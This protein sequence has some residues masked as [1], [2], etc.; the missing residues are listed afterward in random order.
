MEAHWEESR[1]YRHLR[2]EPVPRPLCFALGHRVHESMT[3]RIARG[4]EVTRKVHRRHLA[5]PHDQV[6]GGRRSAH[7]LRDRAGCLGRRFGVV[8]LSLG[9]A[10]HGHAWGGA[11]GVQALQPESHTRR[12]EGSHF[13]EARLAVCKLGVSV[14]LRRS[15]ERRR[16][17]ITPA[18]ACYTGCFPPSGVVTEVWLWSHHRNF[19]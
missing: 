16:A 11:T 1:C 10:L 7:W 19:R 18:L 9:A 12:H 4:Y 13:C 8:F 17:P 5:Y 15:P 2:G 14:S 6:S 3:R